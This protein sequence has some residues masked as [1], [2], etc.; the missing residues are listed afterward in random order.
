M[1][2]TLEECYMNSHANAKPICHL[3]TL[4]Y[5]CLFLIMKNMCLFKD[6][7]DATN[8][9]TP[10]V[11]PSAEGAYLAE[12]FDDPWMFERDWVMAKASANKLKGMWDREM[13]HSS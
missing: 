10:Y 5:P 8:E 1:Y 3:F 12:H 9:P 7:D 6:A 11:S 2:F 4:C 13:T